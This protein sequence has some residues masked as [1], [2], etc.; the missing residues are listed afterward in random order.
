MFKPYEA[1]SSYEAKQKAPE[2]E[3]NSFRFLT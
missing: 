1:M 2:V 3:T